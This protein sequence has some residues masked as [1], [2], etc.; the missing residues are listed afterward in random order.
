MFQNFTNLEQLSLRGVNISSVL[1]DRLNISSSLR[2][3]NL[4]QTGTK[5]KLPHYIF[6]FRSLE[7]LTLGVNDFTGDLPSEISVNLKHLTFLDLQCNK[8]NGTLPSWLFTSPSLEYLLLWNNTF[9]GKVPF[10]SF[11]LP[12]LKK[13]YLS[14]NNQLAGQID[15]QTFRQ[16][17]NLTVL[18][19]LFSNFSGELEL[20]TLLSSLKNLESLRLSYSGFSVT[21][22]NTNHYVNPSFRYLQLA[23]CKLKVFPNSFRVMK[24]LAYLDLNSNLIQGPL[25]PTIGNMSNLL[26]LDISSNL[27][28]GP[29]PPSICKLSNLQ[30]LDMSNNSFGGVIPECVGSMMS[31]LYMID[32]GTNKFHGTIP[33]VLNECLFLE[34]FILNGNQLE[35]E[36]PHSLSKCWS[37]KVLDLGDNKLNGTFPEWLG[38]LYLQN[39]VSDSTK[40]EYLSMGGKYYSMIVVVKDVQLT[41]TKLLVG[42]TIVD[43]SNNR[44][45]GE[46][47][48]TIGSLNSLKVLNLSHNNLNGEISNALGKLLGTESLDLSWNQLIGEIPQS[49]AEIKGT[50]FNTFDESS[51]KG[52]LGLCGLPLIKKCSE[53]T[54]KQELESHEEESGFTWEVVTLGYGCETLLGLVMGYFMLSTRK[55]KWFNVI[56]D[57]GEHMILVLSN[58]ALN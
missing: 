26:S 35:G 39:M 2:L 3:L 50:Q 18:D 52:N 16:L 9:S 30:S 34:G 13:L 8:L 53:H 6:N 56:A 36:V 32:L 17:T 46:I 7:T 42:Y 4:F 55:V 38:G 1:L 15:V 20:D 37:L 11:S 22:N 40:L 14:H 5:G 12:S 44:F 23:S 49:L 19:L 57:A 21:T 54:H 45:E 28:Q 43:L 29:F 51:F 58:G 25:P 48:N 27:I 47:S 31:R 33:N 24:Q 10:E 41:S